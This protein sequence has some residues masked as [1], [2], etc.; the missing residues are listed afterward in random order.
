M[1]NI[2]RFEYIETKLLWGEG[3]TISELS[4]TFGISRQAGQSIVNQYRQC[5]PDQMIYDPKL[6]RHFATKTFVPKYVKD[7]AKS[8]LDYL[9]GQTL[10]QYYKVEEDWSDIEVTDVNGHLQPPVRT[11]LTRILF[12]ALRREK[13][14]QIHYLKKEE[15]S[16]ET[17]LR[18]ISPNHLVFANNRY[19]L[20]AYCHFRKA[21]RDFVLSNILT[22]D[23]SGDEWRSSRED[24]EWNTFETIKLIPNPELPKETQHALLQRFEV[25]EGFRKII[26]RKAI[27]YYIEQSPLLLDPI[28]KK[29][30]WIKT[31]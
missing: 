16:D 18:V 27:A 6:K 15:T 23:F 24:I 5:H 20:R 1:K 31:E 8:F 17:I 10:S 21:Y 4:E 14:L 28:S 25:K 19:H 12:T 22:A 9:R 26:C 29:P 7:D 30:L 11:P 13:S 3:M 2:K